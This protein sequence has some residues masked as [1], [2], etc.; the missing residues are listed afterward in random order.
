MEMFRR[1]LC[2]QSRTIKAICRLRTVDRLSV[3]GTLQDFGPFF[4][5][6][7]P[8]TAA[9]CGAECPSLD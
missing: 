9:E 3:S 4:R 6:A 1:L 8:E 5:L 2:T 7:A